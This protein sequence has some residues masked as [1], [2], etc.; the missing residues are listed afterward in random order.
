MARSKFKKKV[1]HISPL[2]S[3]AEQTIANRSSQGKAFEARWFKEHSR[4]GKMLD[5]VRME[6]IA[7]VRPLE[8]LARC[9]AKAKKPFLEHFHLMAANAYHADLIAV[10]GQGS[11]EIR[12]AIDVSSDMEI[13]LLYRVEAA[14]KLKQIQNHLGPIEH[15]VLERVMISGSDQTLAKLWPKRSE[16]DHAKEHIRSA[17][18]ELA[19][20]YGLISHS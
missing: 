18:S 5:N 3:A 4:D 7:C 12:E 19:K 20:I 6:R 8:G 15:K 10:Q 2:V 13:A 1:Q 14:Q 11:H 16:R 9:H 17:L